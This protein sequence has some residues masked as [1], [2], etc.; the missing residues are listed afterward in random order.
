MILITKEYD[1][2]FS[3]TSINDKVIGAANVMVVYYLDSKVNEI[4]NLT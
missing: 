3:V 2:K 1:I 4:L